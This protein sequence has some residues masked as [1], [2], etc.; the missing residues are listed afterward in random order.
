VAKLETL[1]QIL[2]VIQEADV[3]E[4]VKQAALDDYPTQINLI[5]SQQRSAE[6]QG[7]YAAQ[8]AGFGDGSA[9]ARDSDR[10]EHRQRREACGERSD[11][12]EA[13]RF[14]CEL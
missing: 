10:D 6:Q 7:E 1:Y 11:S 12:N 13:G 4:H 9:V 3:D 5:D 2:R 8:L 14:L